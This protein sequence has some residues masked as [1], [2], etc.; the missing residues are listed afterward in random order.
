MGIPAD[1]D[2]DEPP[3]PP[4]KGPMQIRS[5]PAQTK[6]GFSPRASCREMPANHTPLIEPIFKNL[7][8]QARQKEQTSN[9]IARGWRSGWS[10][11]VCTLKFR[12][13]K[14][15]ILGFEATR[16][17]IVDQTSNF[18]PQTTN[19]QTSLANPLSSI[20]RGAKR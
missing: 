16:T 14:F 5:P 8:Q 2:P 12:G 20:G 6:A 3:T 15:E 10:Y 19:Q 13:L 7:R 17:W 9:F 11:E 18:Q 4:A 1:A